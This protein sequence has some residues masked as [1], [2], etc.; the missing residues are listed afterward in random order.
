M[1][2]GALPEKVDIVTIDVAF[3][4]LEKVL[5]AIKNILKEKGCV[6]ALIKR[7]LRQARKRLEKKA[8]F[9]IALFISKL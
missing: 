3:I 2:E 9:A 8:L 6:I 5:P 4:S 1:E 7:S